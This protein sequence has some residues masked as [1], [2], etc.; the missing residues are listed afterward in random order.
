[1]I[2]ATDWPSL[3]GGAKNL[4]KGVCAISGVYD[5]KP[6]K[7]SYIQK[8]LCF[9]DAE[10]LEYSPILLDIVPQMPV[11]VGVGKNESNEFNRQSKD[12]VDN[13]NLKDAH[14]RLMVIPECNH[15]TVLSHL[16]E[17][18]SLLAEAVLDQMGLS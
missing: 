8:T 3:F 12:L 14:C 6:V 18:K 5:L 4:I 16:A 15:F 2:A 11:I 17:P 13:W 10:V 7:A 1:M 9:T